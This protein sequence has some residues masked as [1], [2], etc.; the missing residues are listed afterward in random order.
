MNSFLTVIRFTFGNKVK[1]KSFVIT[2]LILALLLSVGVHVPYFI[3]LFS[4]DTVHKIGMFQ[5]DSNV[6]Q[7]LQ[8][9]AEAQEEPP[10][11][12][13]ILSKAIDQA[14]ADTIIRDLISSGEVKG[15]LELDESQAELGMFPSGKYK[16]ESSL[17]FGMLSRLQTALNQ[18][19]TEIVLKDMN[20]TDAQKVL[21]FA[22]V[23]IDNVQI[24]VSGDAGKV[25]ES[26]DESQ[27]AIAY[28]MV[29]IL[30]IMQFMGIMITGQLIATEITAEK[31]TRIMEIL[32]TSVS[33]LKQM[34]GKIIGM[35]L[36]GLTQI[37]LFVTV[38]M[39][40][41]NLPHNADAFA[42]FN[43]NLS[44][45]DPALLGYFILFYLGGYF[46]YATLFAAVGSI[47]SRTEDLGQAI[48]PITFLSLAAF[49]IGIYA[50]SQ[51][52]SA[53]TVAMSYVPFFSPLIMFLRIGLAEPALWE[54]ALSAA[55]L[56]V[57]I[58]AMGWL[59][60]KIYRTGVLMYGK[61]PSFK[62]LRKAMRAFKV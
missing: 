20:L 3:Q 23:S 5:S 61:R 44:D 4:S 7:L 16:S 43:I 24:S 54:V 35:L 25:G 55:I 30:M 32:V 45:I 9:Y 37:A 14:A 28:G 60:A 42:G 2:S 49:Y 41:L 38:G 22:P 48:M 27:V 39:I 13:T 10:F 18:I 50:M 31:N 56:A 17:E 58:F 51:P 59:S 26:K 53:F 19:K 15:F 12:I 46:L 29:Y 47:V 36:I 11:E 57:S 1:S 6:P 34:F 21:L 62:E 52:A 8:A 40:N 33:P